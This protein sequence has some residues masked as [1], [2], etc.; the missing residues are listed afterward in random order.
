MHADLVRYQITVAAPL[1]SPIA[2]HLTTPDLH[3]ARYVADSNAAGGSPHNSRGRIHAHAGQDGA[4]RRV[5]APQEDR[6]GLG[7]GQDKRAM[8]GYSKSL[9]A[10]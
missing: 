10:A 5:D 3:P 4:R 2:P 7:R 9:P 6:K 8:P 1:A